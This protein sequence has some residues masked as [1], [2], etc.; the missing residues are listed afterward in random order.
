MWDAAWQGRYASGTTEYIILAAD[1]ERRTY[2][3][4]QQ[5]KSGFSTYRAAIY[6]GWDDVLILGTVGTAGTG[7]TYQPMRVLSK[8]KVEPLGAACA[9][10]KGSGK[11][12]LFTS[13]DAVR[14]AMKE[15]QK[16]P[17]EDSKKSDEP[18]YIQRTDGKLSTLNVAT[19]IGTY[20]DGEGVHGLL[21][22][23]QQSGLPSGLAAG[24]QIVAIDA[25]R[26]ASAGELLLR[27]AFEKPGTKVRLT[28]L[29]QATKAEREVEVT[30]S[31]LK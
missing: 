4:A 24:D 19:E 21:R 25:E 16:A 8:D 23:T 5:Q 26:A 29:D 7:A 11:T 17:R 12:C 3:I 2:L 10:P 18:R 27:I 14:E 9:V 31:A 30:T 15:S 6:P 13:I 1:A 28:V 20:E 22:V